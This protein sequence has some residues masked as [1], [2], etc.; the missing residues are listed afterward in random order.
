VRHHQ[1]ESTE[2]T[3]SQHTDKKYVCSKCGK[4]YA[5]NR[6]LKKH[7]QKYRQTVSD[8]TLR[9]TINHIQNGVKGIRHYNFHYICVEFVYI[10]IKLH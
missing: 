10:N 3:N 8:F 6:D 7:Q 2:H 4:K 1:N 9:S 5:E